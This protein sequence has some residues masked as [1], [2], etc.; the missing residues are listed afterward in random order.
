MPAGPF[1]N[2]VWNAL[3]SEHARF[4]M[5]SRG[6]VRYPADV[7]PYAALADANHAD[8]SPLQELLAPGEQVYLIGPQPTPTNNLHVGPPLNCFQ[9]I[10]PTTADLR[11]VQRDG[12]ATAAPKIIGAQ[13]QP[14]ILSTTPKDAPDMVA[15]TDLAFP[16]FF[17]PRT[18]Q[19]GAYYGIR[20]HK[21]LVAMA[22]ERLTIPG[23]REIS[24]VVTHP[25]HTGRGYATL[26]M[27]RLLQDH[28]AAGLQS[29]LHVS[30]QNARA[31]A[32]YKRMGF[33]ALASVALW[34]ISRPL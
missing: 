22:G 33:I 31:I 26:L 16:G 21:E 2:L 1:H 29:F 34:P 11:D 27:N 24:A 15:L 9:M 17:R 3:H 7:V 18:H 19:M 30:E 20:I 13:S 14:H 32:I 23:Y 12:T 4:A 10:Y 28:T 6:A 5:H 8:L 25:A